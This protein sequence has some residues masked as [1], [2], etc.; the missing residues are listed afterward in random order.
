MSR[1]RLP[2]LSLAAVL[3][4][5][6]LLAGCATSGGP[7]QTPA[8]P[9]AP[10]GSNPSAPGHVVPPTVPTSTPDPAVTPKSAP[11]ARVKPASITGSEE[12]SAMFDNF[13]AYI[14][15][16]DG[17]PVGDRNGWSRPLA[18]TPGPHRLKVGF[19]RGVFFARTDVQITARAGA[20]Y[21]LKFD[22]DAHVF[23]KNS[24]C[25]FWIEDTATGEKALAPTRVP[26]SRAEQGK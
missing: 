21:T 1:L 5:V 26:L 20:R 4:V 3:A 10:V 18:L 19:I 6:L 14:A 9:S 24:Y 25:E 23:G 7:D 13:T 11:E 22:S 16:I 12:T 8:N 15:I 17:Q 2:A